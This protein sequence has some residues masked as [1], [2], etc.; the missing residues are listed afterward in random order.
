MEHTTVA[1]KVEVDLEQ[2]SPYRVAL[3]LTYT[4]AKAENKLNLGGGAT[5]DRRYWLELYQTCRR[6]VLSGDTAAN[7]LKS[8]SGQ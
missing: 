6:V 8:I 2:N 3:E 5:G 1:D 7:A 4:I